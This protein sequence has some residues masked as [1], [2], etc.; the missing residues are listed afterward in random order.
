[1]ST[2]IRERMLVS[3][4]LGGVMFLGGCGSPNAL[5]VAPQVCENATEP[6]L[7]PYDLPYR[8]YDVSFIQGGAVED[9]D[10]LF[11]LWLYCYPPS[12]P[13]PADQPN[14]IE[15][16]GVYGGWY[17]GGPKVEG[18]TQDYWGFGSY[19]SPA[20]GVIGPLYKAKSGYRG[21]I[22]MSQEEI[23]E[24]VKNGIPF[25]FQGRIETPVGVY[26]AI[27]Q[28]KLEPTLEGHI[29]AEVTVE[30]LNK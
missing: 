20:S 1:M 9:G 16:L 10:F 6:G 21:G 18:R 4:L 30:P 24:Y 5:K 13:S 29:P 2:A 3:F 27:L 15:G 26:G 14:V 11:D 19:V 22:A 12:Q 23:I 28:F 8:P 17:Y 7:P 25:Q